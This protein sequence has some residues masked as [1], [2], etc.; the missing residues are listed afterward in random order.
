M[1]FRMMKL[2]TKILKTLM[3][4][5]CCYFFCINHS[6]LQL[7]PTQKPQFHMELG[8]RYYLELNLN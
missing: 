7:W 8:L 1:E 3:P 4:L 6:P 2:S 5:A